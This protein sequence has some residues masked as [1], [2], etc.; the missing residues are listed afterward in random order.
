[1]ARIL[2]YNNDTNRMVTFNRDLN[3]PMPYNSGGT[4]TVREF[5]GSS[6]SSTLWTSLR[7][8][9][10]WNSFRYLYGRGIYVGFAFKRPWEG[11]HS[12]LSQ[13]YAGLAFDVGQ[14]LSQSGRTTLRNLAASSGIWNYV[15]PISLTPRW[16][17]FDERQVAAGYPQVRQGARGVYVCVL[18]DSLNTLRISNWWIRWCFWGS[19]KYR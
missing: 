4:L 7:C 11:G 8:M 15:E 18:Q 12:R 13:H 14:N 3:Q 10:A 9:E 19:D 5:R 17:H 16:V 2:V 6:N 1:M